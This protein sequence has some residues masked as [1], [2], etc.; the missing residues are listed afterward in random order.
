[1]EWTAENEMICQFPISH[2]DF[3]V[4]I[5]VSGFGLMAWIES[6]LHF[7]EES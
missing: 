1:M 5:G 7:A 6:S 3:C 4:E 2:K